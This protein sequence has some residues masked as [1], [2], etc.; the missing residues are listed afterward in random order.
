MINVK[1]SNMIIEKVNNIND[2]KK[3]SEQLTLK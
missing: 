3:C 2:A 1:E